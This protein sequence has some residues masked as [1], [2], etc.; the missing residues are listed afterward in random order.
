M[1][2]WKAFIF[3][4]FLSSGFIGNAHG[5]NASSQPNVDNWSSLEKQRDCLNRGLSPKCHDAPAGLPKDVKI[6]LIEIPCRNCV[7]TD[8]LK[9]ETKTAI[10]HGSM[11]QPEYALITLKG[12]DGQHY[13]FGDGTYP[14]LG[15]QLDKTL[16]RLLNHGAVVLIPDWEYDMCCVDW[17]GYNP[18]LRGSENHLERLLGVA[19]YAK[20]E[21]K[22]I[23]VYFLG[24]SNGTVSL[25]Q[26]SKHIRKDPSGIELVN[27][28]VISAPLKQLTP[29]F[30][31]LHVAYMGHTKDRCKNTTWSLVQK[32]YNKFAAGKSGF[33]RRPVTAKSHTL[34]GI[35]EGL[36]GPD[37][38]G[39]K[40]GRGCSGGYHSYR[41]SDDEIIER[42][43]QL[44][45]K[46]NEHE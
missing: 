43:S 9:T 26:L 7:K 13:G 5:E 40:G 33:N 24:H 36:D 3:I 19:K 11:A 2:N 29:D 41:E 23:P 25:D 21:F 17:G 18:R 8:K 45:F 4:F 16:L 1:I 42:L 27:G 15:S 35:S 38:V 12:G 31:D 32:Q 39:W 28:L 46:W 10:F 37:S 20:H 30:T 34:I 22:G 44:F 14:D 6:S